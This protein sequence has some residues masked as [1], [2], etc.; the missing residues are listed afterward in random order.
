M[1]WAVIKRK[2]KMIIAFSNLG[3]SVCSRLC[4]L[5]A[6]AI[7]PILILFCFLARLPGASKQLLAGFTNCLNPTN[8]DVDCQVE[9]ELEADE[10]LLC[11]VLLMVWHECDLTH[12]QRIRYHRLSRPSCWW[13]N[14]HQDPFRGF[15]PPAF[16]RLGKSNCP[17]NLNQQ[18]TGEASFAATTLLAPYSLLFL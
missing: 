18:K 11:Q 17:T 14:C 2:Q 1:K 15:P 8:Q 4:F 16:L 12:T 7:K 10:C 5:G 9:K 3:N 6:F 13:W